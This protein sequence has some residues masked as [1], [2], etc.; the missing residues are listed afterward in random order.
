MTRLLRL[1]IIL[2]TSS[3]TLIVNAGIVGTPHDFTTRGW[4]TANPCSVCH[5]PHNAQVVPG[6]PL[7]N[8]TITVV[9]FQPYT[10]DSLKATVNQPGMVSKL[11]LSCHDGSVAPDSFNMGD[12]GMKVGTAT[13]AGNRQISHNGN[14]NMDHPI[15]FAYDSTLTAKDKGLASP[16][17]AK[18][19][20]GMNVIPLYSGQMECSSCHSAHDNSNKMFLRLDNSGGALCLTC[21]LK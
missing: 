9:V 14:L 12:T 8:H 13:I 17:S 21:H 19:V 11:C 1:L 2:A 18:W 5:T 7:W 6:A 3:F 16:T 4:G 20:D 15:G 10:S